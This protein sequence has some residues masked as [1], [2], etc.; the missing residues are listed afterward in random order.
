MFSSTALRARIVRLLWQL[1]TTSTFACQDRRSS[2]S[3]VVWTRISNRNSRFVSL[4]VDNG[5]NYA[6]SIN[7]EP[8]ESYLGDPMLSIW[9]IATID[10]IGPKL[11]SMQP[12]GAG[13]SHAEPS[14]DSKM[15]MSQKSATILT[16][17]VPST[18][19]VAKNTRRFEGS[20]T[21]KKV[22]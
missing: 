1:G 12:E 8:V 6:N 17:R 21:V 22:T 14:F 20:T 9:D 16:T 15:S 7:T 11:E 13:L 19:P 10:K 5:K 4:I 2:S 18:K 3:K